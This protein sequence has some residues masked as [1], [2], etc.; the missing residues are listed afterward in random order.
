VT[1]QLTGTNNSVNT[2][3]AQTTP[4]LADNS[5]LF[6][7]NAGAQTFNNAQLYGGGQWL[8]PD[9]FNPSSV[10][11]SPGQAVFIN[12]IGAAVKLLVVG[13][14]PTGALPVAVVQN[15][16]FYADPAPVS[17]N[18]ATNGFPIGDNDLLYTWNP[19]S[20]TYN[21]AYLGQATPPA[22][23]DPN[24]FTPVNYA[25]AVGEGFVVNRLGTAATWNRSF[26]V[27]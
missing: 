26:A 2:V 10:T 11:V 1:A 27:Q 8:D 5:L 23:L 20:Q 7:W 4:A 21:N 18:I 22:W 13:Q 16:G 19:G 12:N 3:L 17:Q 6:T 24:T 14:V 25:P 15:L 9:T